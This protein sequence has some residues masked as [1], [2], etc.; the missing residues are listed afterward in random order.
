[1]DVYLDHNAT[2]PVLPEVVGA[3]SVALSQPGNASSVHHY[4]R[5]VRR[6]IDDARE[7]VARLVGTCAGNVVFTSGGTEAN[8]LALR[9]LGARTMVSAVEHE[10]VLSAREDAS[11]IPVDRNGRVDLDQLALNAGSAQQASQPA[12]SAT[13]EPVHKTEARARRVH[14]LTSTCTQCHRYT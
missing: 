2:T 9:G 12:R 5:L 14:E 10:S 3:M 11:L 13:Q 4:G 8:N 1:M 7:A 6:T